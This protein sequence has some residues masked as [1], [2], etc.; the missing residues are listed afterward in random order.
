MFMES[1][2]L[3]HRNVSYIAIFCPLV[4]LV[5]ATLPSLQNLK[6]PNQGLNPL[7]PAVEAQSPKHWTAREFPLP[8]S[9]TLTFL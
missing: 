8:S 5:L 4:V 3:S 1:E 7:P 9:F 2:S 6:L